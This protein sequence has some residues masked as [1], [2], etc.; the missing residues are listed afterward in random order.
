MKK[1]RPCKR[2]GCKRF[3]FH[4][5]F[6]STYCAKLYHG[7]IQASTLT[8]YEKEKLRKIRQNGPEY[9]TVVNADAMHRRVPGSFES[10]KR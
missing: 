1:H 5:D 9:V 2:K 10:A 4:D 7:V 6:C 8:K 3:A